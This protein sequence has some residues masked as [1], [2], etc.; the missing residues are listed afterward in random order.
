MAVVITTLVI[1]VCLA[2]EPNICREERMPL[3]TGS[4]VLCMTQG[5]QVAAQWLA[6]H[7]SWVLRGWRCRFGGGNDI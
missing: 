5:Q 7:P 1:V 6:D 2:A 4:G 3:D